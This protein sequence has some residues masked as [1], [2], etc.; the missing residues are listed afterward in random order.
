MYN[1]NLQKLFME[2][3]LSYPSQQLY[4]R[5]FKQ[6]KILE[7][8]A[9]NDK[10]YQL[11]RTYAFMATSGKLGPKQ[12]EG[13]LQIPEGFYLLTNFNPLS[14]Y[15][16]SLK[17][18]YPNEADI[19]RN[20]KEKNIGSDIYI[21]GGH[22]TVGCIPIG[23]ENIGELYWLCVQT[24]AL[25]PLIHIHIFPCKMEENNLKEIYKQNPSHINFW[26]SL[27]PVYARFHL[28]KT[29]YS[30]IHSDNFGNYALT[31]SIDE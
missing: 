2:N 8:W 15:R 22:E 4:I 31:N 16:L 6:E 13:D 3:E 19:I 26:N 29:L 17:I 30:K 27:I 12:Q 11:I 1:A 10:Q 20:K 21:H 23:D 28:T 7:V 5:A 25:N 14:K 9:S 24:Y 18:N